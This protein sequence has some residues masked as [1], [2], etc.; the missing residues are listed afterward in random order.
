[1]GSHQITA[2]Y[3]GNLS[4]AGST[5]AVLQQLV[6][7]ASTTTLTS[8]ANPTCYRQPVTF[9]AT[10]SGLSGLP[11]AT[12]TVTL[13]EFGTVTLATAALA[14]A[15]GNDQATFT[16]SSLPGG[17]DPIT[18]VYGGDGT[19]A[20]STSA[21]LQQV[22]NRPPST[23]TLTSSDNPSNF[24]HP[25]TFTA[26]VP[27]LSGVPPPTGTVY[28][29]DGT[30][31]LGSAS[32]AVAG[33]NDQ[34]T[35]TISSLSVGSHQITAIYLGDG[36]YP[37]GYSAPVDQQV[38]AAPHSLVVTQAR[39]S[40]PGTGGNDPGDSYV[41]LANTSAAPM[42]LAG[43]TLKAA[44]AGG[45]TPT[46]IALPA[47]VT[48]LP[49]QSLLVAGGAYSLDTAPTLVAAPD[50]ANALP[51]NTLGVQVDPPTGAPVD[52]VGYRTA[53][54]GYHGA[55]GGLA[56]LGDTGAAQYAF[57][58]HGSQAVPVDTDNNA[59]DFSLV[60]TTGGTVGGVS[61]IL[62]SP[63]P[64]STT[65]PQQV[66]AQAP[67]VLM[68][69]NVAASQSPNRIY[70]AGAP[71]TLVVNRTITNNTGKTITQL[72]LRITSLTE[73]DGPPSG[74]HA[75]L[76]VVASTA[77][78]GAVALSPNAPVGTNGGGLATTIS[79]T[80]A[81]SLAPGASLSVSFQFAV[82]QGGSFSFGYDIDAS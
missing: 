48:L 46:T 77:N 69:P 74:A 57:V 44:T 6:T 7:A 13:Y 24:S 36:N 53:P 51:S 43:W 62:G 32:L 71:G 12:G 20:G 4:S 27:G 41:D 35:F 59:G 76:R 42:S 65:S 25:V 52:V 22:V 67:S 18:A 56:P 47:A 49:G 19:Y 54:A 30:A 66:N 3:Q 9:T 28:F 37:G 26:T 2:V 61:S 60:S 29:D 1:V 21:V 17:T 16:I 33:G 5:S 39:F 34:A 50:L 10:V 8:S 81:V 23:P 45:G 58:R 79:P 64:L 72:R 15:G 82:D 70:T 80:T 78:H 31:T 73:Q 38:N 14:V 68:D 63:S 40:G 75:W 55:A 11:P